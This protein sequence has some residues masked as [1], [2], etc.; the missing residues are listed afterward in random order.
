[1]VTWVDVENHRGVI[2]SSWK[3]ISRSQHSQFSSKWLKVDY[4]TS[5][6]NK[7]V[8]NQ[9]RYIWYMVTSVG[10]WFHRGVTLKSWWGH[11]KVK[12]RSNQLKTVENNLF[13]LTLCSLVMYMMAWSIPRPKQGP[14]LKHTREVIGIT[15][16]LEGFFTSPPPL[17]LSLC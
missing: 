5:T 13:L 16:G 1:M 12:A 2:P 11:L 9:P 17:K 4:W 10:V 15:Q 14:T 3:V 6:S 7:L 8:G